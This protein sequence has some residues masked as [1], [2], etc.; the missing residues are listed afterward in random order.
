MTL[1]GW[2]D[3]EEGGRSVVRVLLSRCSDPRALLAAAL[4]VVVSVVLGC[5][6]PVTSVHRAGEV[7]AGSKWA[8]LPVQNHSETPQAGERVEAILETLLRKDGVA[9][10]DRYPTPK[11]GDAHLFT[12]DRQRYE[13][14]LEWARGS[15]YDYAVTGSVEEWR[16]KSGLDGEPA[17]GV[18]MQVV[19]LATGKVLWAATGTQTGSSTENASGTALKLLDKLVQELHGTR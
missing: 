7:K 19:E 10:L 5:S 2:G 16:Y 14:A 1:G 18:S 9:K 4:L 3:E 13:A 12:S 17:I 8:L 6:S 15:K 11:D